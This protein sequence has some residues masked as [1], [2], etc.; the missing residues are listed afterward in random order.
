V[1]PSASAP[2]GASGNGDIDL[3]A[4]IDW[5]DV[6]A[7]ATRIGTTPATKSLPRY[8]YICDLTHPAP[9]GPDSVTSARV[10]EEDLGALLS[11]FARVP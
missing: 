7:V 1:N 2:R 3:N 8:S 6:A 11:K 10:K 5:K 4:Q 9:G